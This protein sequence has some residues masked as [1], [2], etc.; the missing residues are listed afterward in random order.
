MKQKEK[1]KLNSN[2]CFSG[3]RFNFRS[4]P[5]GAVV[6]AQD[7]DLMGGKCLLASLAGVDVSTR[8]F[9]HPRMSW[10]FVH[11]LY[12]DVRIVKHQS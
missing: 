2:S 6:S 5:K 7:M 10:K 4:F 9:G 8:S 12:G 11:N 1:N 3:K